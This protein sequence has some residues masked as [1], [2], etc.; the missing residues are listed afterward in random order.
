MPFECQ[1]IAKNL[2]FFP[3]KWQFTG[4][5]DYNV[6][7]FHELLNLKDLWLTFLNTNLTLPS[8]HLKF[9]KVVIISSV[10]VSSNAQ[11][12]LLGD[13]QN[14]CQEWNENILMASHLSLSGWPPVTG[15]TSCD[16]VDLLWLGWPRDRVDLCDFSECSTHGFYPPQLSPQHFKAWIWILEQSLNFRTLENKNSILKRISDYLR[17]KLNLPCGGWWNI[18]SLLTWH[19]HSFFKHFVNI[20]KYYTKSLTGLI[21]V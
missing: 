20:H 13:L 8:N 7:H 9:T 3:K 6:W 4:G 1:K 11:P 12:E 10:P 5:S 17:K 21:N 2:T 18:S 15:L 19:C 16:W 14:L